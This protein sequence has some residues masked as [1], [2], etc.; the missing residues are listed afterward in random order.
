MDKEKVVH[1][2]NGV[3]LSHLKKGHH[4]FCKQMDETRKDYPEG[5]NSEPE[6]QTWYILTY[7]WILVIKYRTTT[8]QNTK[9]KKLSNKEGPRRNR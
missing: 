3:L 4:D 6:R 2:L 1:L 9:P 5:S 7:K 8:L